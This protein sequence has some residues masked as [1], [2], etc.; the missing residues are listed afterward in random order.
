M[1]VRRISLIESAT[2]SL[3]PAQQFVGAVCDTCRR[4]G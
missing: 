2:R 4:P 3:S 1:L